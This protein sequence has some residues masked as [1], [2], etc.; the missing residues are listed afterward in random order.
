MKKFVAIFICRCFGPGIPGDT[1]PPILLM[2]I[3]NIFC[4]PIRIPWEGNSSPLK[5]P[6]F[7]GIPPRKLTWQWKI[8]HLKIYFL[9]KMGMF[10]CHV[11]FLGVYLL[12]YQPFWNIFPQPPNGRHNLSSWEELL[13]SLQLTGSHLKIDDWKAIVSFWGPAFFAGA[14]Q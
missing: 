6:P 14:N 9:L 10:H 1:V 7:W 13:P 8:N 5:S 4:W 11:Y 3:C 12:N 2:N